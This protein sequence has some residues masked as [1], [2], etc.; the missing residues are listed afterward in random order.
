ML[1]LYDKQRN[2]YIYVDP[3]TGEQYESP[4][5]FKSAPKLVIEKQTYIIEPVSDGDICTSILKFKLDISTSGINVFTDIFATDQYKKIKYFVDATYVC[6][7]EWDYWY[8]GEL[9]G[10]RVIKFFD[11]SRCGT[12]CVVINPPVHDDRFINVVYTTIPNARS[13]ISLCCRYHPITVYPDERGEVVLPSNPAELVEGDVYQYNINLSVEDTFK[14]V[15]VGIANRPMSITTSVYEMLHHKLKSFKNY[16]PLA[17][18][19]ASVN[20]QLGNK[21]STSGVVLYRYP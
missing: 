11:L 15:L 6:D 2:I 13:D 5:N 17:I 12:K 4:T 3:V 1:R 9:L 20:T 16:C 21:L 14:V 8:F 19:F 18:Q 10:L 7:N